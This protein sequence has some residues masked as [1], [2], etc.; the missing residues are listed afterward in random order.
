MLKNVFLYI[1]PV[2]S[3][4][5]TC[6]R[7]WWHDTA[8]LGTDSA[9]PGPMSQH[10]GTNR[11]DTDLLPC[12]AVPCHVVSCLIVLVPVPCRAARFAIYT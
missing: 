10:G 7:V 6:R 5:L 8:R 12:L 11:H 2:L 1:V 9:V 3:L 4:A